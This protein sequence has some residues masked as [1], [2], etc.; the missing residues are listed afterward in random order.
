M[1]ARRPILATVLC[2]ATLCLA[3]DMLA[4]EATGFKRVKPP[5]PG[6]GRL[7]DIQI[8]PKAPVERVLDHV[9][10]LPPEEVRPPMAGKVPAPG[11]TAAWFWGSVSVGFDGAGPGRLA[12]AVAVL[13]AFLDISAPLRPNPV[14]VFEIGQDYGAEILKATAGTEVSPAL[15]LAMMIVESNGNPTA[16]STAGAVGLMQLMPSTAK[17]F[18]VT[19]RTDPAQSIS[20]GVQYLQFLLAEFGGDALLAAAAYNAGEGAVRRAGGVP[21]YEETRAYVPKVVAAWTQAR[22]LCRTPPQ[23]ASDACMFV[24]LQLAQQ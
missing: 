11:D 22:M 16:K 13:D 15:V 3:P 6:A 1:A 19:D 14:R 9:P 8:E 20:G 18:G 2:L 7:I 4:A 24:G 23:D 12:D 10:D 5:A 17:R 21:D